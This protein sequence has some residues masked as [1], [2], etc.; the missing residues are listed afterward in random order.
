ML[1]LLRPIIWLLGLVGVAWLVIWTISQLLSVD[2][3]S[4]CGQTP[5]P[6]SATCQEADVIVAISG[7]DTNARAQEAIDLYRHGWA[8]RIIF[9]GAAEDTTGESNAAAM[10]QQAL[11]EG[12]PASAI[13]L[14]QK[15]VDTAANASYVATIVK[16]IDAKRLILVTSPYHQRRASIEFTRQLGKSVIIINHPTPFDRLW[17]VNSWWQQPAGWWLAGSELVKLF[18]VEVNPSA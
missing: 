11:V 14:D 12:V 4:S 5:N 17:P 13:L 9:S 15:S 10:Q 7:G 6:Q 2:D 1:F 3:L 8:P 18:I 16:S